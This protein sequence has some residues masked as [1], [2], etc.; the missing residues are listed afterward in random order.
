MLN[1][2]LDFRH[3]A[4]VDDF[5]RQLAEQARWRAGFGANLDALW[6][7]LTGD[8]ALPARIRLKHW[9]QHPHPEQF[10]ALVGVLREA[11]EELDGALTIRI[12]H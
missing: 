10:T 7:A 4:N 3:I 6:D 11:E 8:L 9:R 2:T 5:Y 12:D 1:I